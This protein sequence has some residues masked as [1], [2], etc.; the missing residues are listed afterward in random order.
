MKPL[1]AA[2]TGIGLFASSSLFAASLNIPMAFEY[3][4]VDGQQVK[5]SVVMH[6]SR[7][8]LSQ[9]QHEIALRYSDMV[10]ANAMETPESV[11][12]PA[13]IITLDAVENVDYFLTTAD[14]KP[15]RNAK[16]F[17]RAPD[18]KIIRKDGGQ[19]DYTLTH[20]EITDKDFATHLYGQEAQPAKPAVV[21]TTAP[22]AAMAAAAPTEPS[23]LQS[24]PV[25]AAAASA[26]V[27]AGESNASPEQ[28]LRLWWQRADEQTRRDFL[29]WAIKQL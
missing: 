24:A 20:T 10:E 21:A 15:V 5:R 8:D 13:F 14:G 28:M 4:A 2:I 27:E 16:E 3:L 18:V 9:G 26:G 23:Q 6:K 17:A 29:A 7:L 1:L 11:K 12:S 25:A 19:V 22:T